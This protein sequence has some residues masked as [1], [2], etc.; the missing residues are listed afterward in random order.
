M[1]IHDQKIAKAHN[2]N[3]A[4]KALKHAK[5]KA[6]KAEEKAYRA[7]LEADNA[8]V[9]VSMAEETLKIMRHECQKFVKNN[10]N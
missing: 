7:R 6:R 2:I 5:E 4:I 1:T 10:G 9:H 3:Y 8:K